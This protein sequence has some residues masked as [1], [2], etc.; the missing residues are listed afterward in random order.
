MKAVRY[1]EFG[2]RKVLSVVD[3][4]VP[5]PGPGQVRI[6]VKA[7]GVNPFDW[8]LRMGFLPIMVSFPAGTGQDA[9]GVVTAVG[10]GVVGVQV[11]SRLGA[12]ASCPRPVTAHAA[13][14]SVRP[15]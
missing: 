6:K 7:S 4:D 3:V 14:A 11:G 12:R 10:D 5:Q 8:K 9:A 13:V 1:T 2:G 15:T